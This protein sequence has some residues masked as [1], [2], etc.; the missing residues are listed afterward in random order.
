M[1]TRK[2]C[3][4][5]QSSLYSMLSLLLFITLASCSPIFKNPI[6]PPPELKADRQILG[7]WVRTL[8]EDQQEYK[9]QLS[10]FPLGGG[11][12][13]VVYIYGIDREEPA[14][15]INLLVF[16]GYSTSVNKQKFLCLRFREKDFNWAHQKDY[17]RRGKEVGGHPFI[18]YWIIVNYE[19]PNNGE[20]IIKRFSTRRVEELIKEGKLK[21]EI[22][23][24]EVF[25][26]L[27]FE[28]V[29]KGQPADD[30]LKRRP[31]DGVG[32]TSSSDE[33]VEL[34]SREG[35]GAF[36]CQDANDVLRDM[37]VL[38]FSRIKP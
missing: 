17:S 26:G 15:G 23:K 22:V 33:L 32:V 5:F 20:L 31:F 29:F 9:E 27:P 6:P 24:A 8:K 34:I 4:R 10:I 38:V 7:T 21:A 16:E 35:V 11:W 25:P 1:M 3:D 36:I 18:V 19:T 28:D 14:D 13:D 37:D 12:I 30:V 2:V